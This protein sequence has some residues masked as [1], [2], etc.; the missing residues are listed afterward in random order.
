[1][2]KNYKK[3]SDMT[4]LSHFLAVQGIVPVVLAVFIYLLVETI[5]V[6]YTLK[7][8]SM[9][10]IMSMIMQLITFVYSKVIYH[11]IFILIDS[12]NMIANGNYD[13]VLNEYNCGPL[14]ELYHN[15]NQM[16]KKLKSVETLRNDFINDFSHEFK[17]PITSINGFAKLLLETDTTEEEKKKYLE[18]IATESERLSNLSKETLMM[19][20]LNTQTSIEN[21][22]SYSLDE[23]IRQCIIL[24]SKEWSEKNID[25]TAELK[26]VNYKGNSDMM[27][28]IWINL[29]NN[30][31]KF[32]P[33]GGKITVSLEEKGEV[34][35]VT[36]IDTGKG[37]TKDVI[38]RIYDKYYQGDSSHS[39]K[40]LGLGLS[41][42][43]KIVNLCGG[44]IEVTSKIEKGSTFTVNLPK[45]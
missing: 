14:K 4:K 17:T 27:K 40:G 39:S 34:I 13:V 24:L 25:V 23:Q 2:N 12:I 6:G 37:I 32:T 1:M 11:Y 30:A 9:L 21:K 42:T 10:V 38:E 3:H 44:T 31:I 45:E 41:I 15:F 36:V 33:A 35:V 26:V 28:H 19:S 20:K 16:T 8:L 43:K 22:V 5:N 29:I 7:V 18:I